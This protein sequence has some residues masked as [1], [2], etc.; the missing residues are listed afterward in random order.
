MSFANSDSFT[1]S[2][3]IS[4]FFSCILEPYLKHMEVPWL[5]VELELQLPAT[6]VQDPSCVCDLYCS[7][8]QCWIPD[9]LSKARDQ[10]HILMDT[11]RIH[12]HCTTVGTPYP[13]QFWC[14]FFFL[15]NCYR[16]SNNMS[17]PCCFVLEEK[18]SFSFSP[19]SLMLA[20]SLSC[21]AFTMLRYVLFMLNFIVRFYH[22]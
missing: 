17:N 1:L 18:L 9:P 19:L 7:S 13:L 6:A 10:T 3:T 11:S 5:G 15:P 14:L 4:F 22:K 12:L 2:F 21:V 20:L 8:Q 16:I